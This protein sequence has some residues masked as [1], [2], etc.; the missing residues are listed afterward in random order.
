MSAKHHD[1]INLQFR[2]AE[3]LK[4]SATRYKSVSVCMIAVYPG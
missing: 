4:K 3:L 2:G 1:G